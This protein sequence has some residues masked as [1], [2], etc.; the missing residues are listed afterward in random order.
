MPETPSIRPIVLLSAAAFA[1]AATLR[2]AD[3]LL[4]QI[5]GEFVTTAGGASVIA[6]AFAVSYGL[7]QIFVGALG[8][9][10]GKYTVIAVATF[11]SGLTAA[12]GA[13]ASSLAMLGVMRLLSGATA[14]A[15]IPLAMAYLGDVVAYEQRQTVLA[16]FLSGQILGVIFGQIFGGLFGDTLGWRGVFLVLGAIYLVITALLV[17]ELRSPRVAQHRI[18][19]GGALLA[20]NLAL[21]QIGRV[22]IIIATAFVEAF[23]FFGGFVYLGAYLRHEFVLSYLAVGTLLA[24]FGI[25]GLIYASTVRPL[26]ARLGERGLALAGGLTLAIAFGLAAAA[27]APWSVAP[28]IAAIGA[29]FYMLHNTLQTNAT[30]MAPTA[31]GLAISLFAFCY[32]L[33]QAAGVAACGW[34]VDEFGYAPVFVIDGAMLLVTALAFRAT[35]A[36]RPAA[37]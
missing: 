26:V 23:F 2:V 32:F 34:A 36:K 28:L 7:C 25:G 10:F 13:L 22:R 27:P 20:R 12:S 35:L 6:T 33:G 9:R 37:S 29:G 16:R 5:A 24:S 1:S 21:L 4:P 30:Q 8:D 3:P 14:G 19:D 11:L 15:I 31:R 17:L 18:R